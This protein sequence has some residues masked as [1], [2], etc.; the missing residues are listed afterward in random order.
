MSGSRDRKLPGRRPT[1]LTLSLLGGWLLLG[2]GLAHGLARFDFEQRYYVHPGQKVGDFCLVKHDSLFHIFYHSTSQSNP[3]P[4]YK[5]WHSWSEDLRHWQEP[6]V[7]LSVG[8][9]WWDAKGMWAPDVVWEPERKQWSMLYTGVDSLMNQRACLATSPDLHTWTKNHA[10]PVFV[11]DSLT[12]YWS[13]TQTWSSFRDP[14]VFRQEGIWVMLSTAALRVGGYPGSRQAIIHRATS[15]DLVSWQDRG[16]FFLNDGTTPWQD[17]ES[18]QYHVRGEGFH[19]WFIEYGVPGVSHI[20]APTSSWTMAD[21]TIVDFGNAPEV[22]ALDEQHDL[23]ARQGLGLDPRTDEIF[24][25]VRLDTMVYDVTGQDP[26][27]LQPH[28]LDDAW[29]ERSGSATIANPTFG[30]NTA[31]RGEE[32]CG[33]VGHGWFGSQEYFQGPLSGRGNAGTKLGDSATGYLTSY[34]FV[35][36]GDSISLL[37]GGGDYP[38]TCYV[39]LVDAAADTV[40]YRETGQNHETMTRRVWP[41]SWLQGRQ[42]VIKI[43]DD[44]QGTFGHINVDEIV[45]YFCELTA[46]PAGSPGSATPLVQ[47]HGVAPNPGNPG[48]AIRFALARSGPCRIRIHDLRGRLVWQE[49]LNVLAPGPHAVHWAGNGQDGRAMPSGTYLY[50]IEVEGRP[51]ASGKLSL[52][53]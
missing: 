22:I 20:S 10:N 48:L 15:R 33:L 47:S 31:M 41:V 18:A 17:L 39:A 52:V 14:F 27:I 28:P 21:R 37:V 19:L 34:P 42:V 43:V 1:W 9:N 45:E 6:E 38:Q 53:R 5:I 3:G 50:S 16:T 51:E 40:L 35:I 29:A 7:A 4:V 13:P 23:F 24:V 2:A 12:Y 32:S 11:P 26:T 44:E 8:P 49:S 25:V 46:S 36:E 30:D